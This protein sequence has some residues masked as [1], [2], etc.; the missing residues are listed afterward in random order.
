[1]DEEERKRIEAAATE[2]ADLANRVKFLEG[3]V[4]KLQAAI[5]W[6]T[7]AIWGGVAY[8]ITQLWTF[9]SQGGSLK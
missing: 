4:V 2:K 8:L 9:I 7:R 5:A 6:G 1:M 3:E